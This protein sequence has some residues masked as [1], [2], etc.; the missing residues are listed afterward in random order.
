MEAI[1]PL[2]AAGRPFHGL[3]GG[4]NGLFLRLSAAFALVGGRGRTAVLVEILAR[5]SVA[6]AALIK[7]WGPW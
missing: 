7:K 4:R 6:H 1:E 3:G 5:V 2:R